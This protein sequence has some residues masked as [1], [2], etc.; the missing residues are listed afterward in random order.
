MFLP[1]PGSVAEGAARTRGISDDEI[2]TQLI[3]YGND[4]P[5]GDAKSLGQVSY[6]ELKGGRIRFNGRDV[7]T[8]PLS[9]YVRALEIAN[10]LR[11]WIQ[12]GEFLITEPQVMLPTVE[13][14]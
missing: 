8:V 12:L 14:G 6:G 1:A 7:Q 4:Y 11:E 9:S 13:R 3:D 5:T 2:F 10:I